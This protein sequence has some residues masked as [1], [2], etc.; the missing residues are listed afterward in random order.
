MLVVW[1]SRLITEIQI[2]SWAAFKPFRWVT[3]FA[4]VDIMLRWQALLYATVSVG[5][6]VERI[7]SLFVNLGSRERKTQRILT[8]KKILRKQFEISTFFSQHLNMLNLIEIDLTFMCLKTLSS[9]IFYYTVHKIHLLET[10]FKGMSRR[11]IHL[12][13]NNIALAFKDDSVNICI[14]TGAW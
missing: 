3:T 6:C 4:V 11:L 13:L 8:W 9:K 10:F 1:Q 7:G 12:P 5:G 2:A 14:F